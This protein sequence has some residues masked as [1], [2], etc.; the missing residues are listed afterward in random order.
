[1]FSPITKREGKEILYSLDNE[2]STFLFPLTMKIENRDKVTCSYSIPS[3][4]CPQL[5]DKESQQRA[6]F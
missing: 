3:L 6:L 2:E 4:L 1:M 5:M